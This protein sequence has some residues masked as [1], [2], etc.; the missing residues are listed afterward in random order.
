MS[1]TA[2]TFPVIDPTV[3][4]HNTHAL[5]DAVLGTL[6]L[7]MIPVVCG[8]ERPPSPDNKNVLA[9]PYDTRIQAKMTPG[10][11]INN[12]DPTVKQI[13]TITTKSHSDLE[14]LRKSG[15]MAK[16]PVQMCR[17][18][19]GKPIMREPC[20]TAL[21]FVATS[22]TFRYKDPCFLVINGQYA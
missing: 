9:G 20:F 17:V 6:G 13:F 4:H 16:N 15:E 3:F 11:V 12:S 19:A 21:E 8:D 5:G 7:F 10:M 14:A 1:L 22:N 18:N 2:I